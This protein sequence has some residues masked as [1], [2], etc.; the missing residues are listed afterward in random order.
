MMD[1]RKIKSVTDRKAVARQ[2][3]DQLEQLENKEFILQIPL[4]V[5]DRNGVKKHEREIRS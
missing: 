1:T 4:I 2:I 3:R 5:T